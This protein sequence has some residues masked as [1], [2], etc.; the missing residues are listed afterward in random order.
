MLEAWEAGGVQ[1]S[2]LAVC[3]KHLFRRD[4]RHARE[5]EQQLG[6]NVR[7]VEIGVGL[8]RANVP[9]DRVVPVAQC[10]LKVGHSDDS[11]GAFLVKRE[12]GF[13]GH[14]GLDRS[15]EHTSELQSHSFIS[16][17]V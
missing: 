6:M 4:G 17:A 8:E 15:E 16:Y 12:C 14:F 3:L 2:P 1:L 9:E 7:A 5:R 10:H 11:G 13:E